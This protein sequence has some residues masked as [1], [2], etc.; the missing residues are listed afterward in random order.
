VASAWL[1][2]GSGLYD[3]EWASVTLQCIVPAAGTFDVGAIFESRSEAGIDYFTDA[4]KLDYIDQVPEPEP[5]CVGLPRIDYA[6]T[7]N[8]IPGDA[9]AERA[10]AI[11]AQCW[12]NGRQTVTGSYDDAGIGDLSEK[13]AVLWDIL[14]AEQSLYVDF[15]ERYYPGTRVV[16]QGES[17]PLPP[18]GGE[19]VPYPAPASLIGLHSQRTKDGWLD[20]LRKVKPGVFKGF[21]IDQ[22]VAAK[23]A[24]PET[25]TVYRR[26]VDND[27]YWLYDMG[28]VA[29]LDLYSAA[30]ESYAANHNMTVAQV[31]QY[32]DIIES[33]NEVIGTYDADLKPAVAFDVAFMD[34]IEKRYGNAVKAG[35]LTIA[36]GN[37]HE[38]EF[39]AL[40][41]AA[42]KA[43]AGGHYLA[44]HPYWSANTTRSFLAANWPQHAGR[45][46]EWDKTFTA[47]GVYPLYYGGESGICYA[48]DGWSFEPNRGWKSCGSFSK[49][50]ADLEAFDAMA[51]EWNRTHGNRFRGMTIFCYGGWGWEDFDF[52][53]GDLAELAEALV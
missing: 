35:V 37:P 39:A 36:V 12:A 4:W 1:T 23:Q 50:I 3:R 49:Y 6:R 17:A 2:Y 32:V 38:S 31:L 48:N 30:F 22:C 28:P 33:V 21:S 43:A 29:F 11:F 16:F 53:P 13:T 34:A 47:A 46:C 51:W 10:E 45:W 41:P 7:V 5:E 8:V 40:L 27:G 14:P 52:E 24:S 18:V 25:L 20:Y 42:R 19:P 15:Y 44:Y 26:H 9:T